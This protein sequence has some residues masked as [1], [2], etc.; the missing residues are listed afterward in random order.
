VRVLKPA[1]IWP[2]DAAVVR[3]FARD[4]ETIL[5]IEDQGPLLETAVR[6]ALYGRVDAPAVIGKADREGRPLLNRAGILGQEAM[7]KA[8]GPELLRLAELPQ[9]TR[10]LDELAAGRPPL[11]VLPLRT[12]VFCSGCPHNRSTD[13]P[14]GAVVGA[15]IGCHSIVMIT[16]A[17]KGA[18]TANTQM[19]AEG[20]QWIGQAPFTDVAHLFQNMGDGTFSHSGSLAVRAAVAAGVNITYKLLFNSAVAMTQWRARSPSTASPGGWRPRASSG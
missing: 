6:D 11:P 19:G 8:L 1:A 7:A 13:V 9:V 17:G 4:L 10:R 12:P 20:A 15:G 5:V 18:V 16:P 14:D 2:L 3:E